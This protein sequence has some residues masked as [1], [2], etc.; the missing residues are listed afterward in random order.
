MSDA[1]GAAAVANVTD[2][3]RCFRV[4]TMKGIGP[5]LFWLLAEAPNTR[6]H[7]VVAAA[8]VVA[9]VGLWAAVT[10]RR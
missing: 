6:P 4:S 10:R 7:V 8:C 3:A 1:A 5:V 9:L 2:I